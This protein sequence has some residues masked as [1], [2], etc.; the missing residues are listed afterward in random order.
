[1]IAVDLMILWILPSAGMGASLSKKP[2]KSPIDTLIEVLDLPGPVKMEGRRPPLPQYMLNLYNQ[3]ADSDGITRGKNPYGAEIIRSYRLSE[4][5][6]LSAGV[7]LTF[8]ISGLKPGEN[9]LEADLHLFRTKSKKAGRHSRHQHVGQVSLYEVKDPRRLEDLSSQRLL[10]SHLISEHAPGW[11]V[12]HIKSAILGGLKGAES[13]FQFL[14]VAK[15]HLDEPM[16]V[17]LALKHSRQPLI[18][19]YDQEAKHPRLHQNQQHRD[20][21]ENDDSWMSHTRRRRST[22]GASEKEDPSSLRTHENSAQRQKPQCSKLDMFVD[23][24]QIGLEQIISPKGYNAY[25]CDGACDYLISEELEPTNHAR[26]QSIAHHLG[27]NEVTPP[28]CVPSS[29]QS[30]TLL[31]FD[32]NH[33]VILRQYEDMVV[34]NCACH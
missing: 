20:L 34:G 10:G 7:V 29:L 15:D 6:N 8:N 4:E 31:F 16:F 12:F 26:V 22:T 1:M 24:H 17:T 25:W 5:Q 14:V 19:L 23:L 11:E 9:I 27:L 21:L 13:R 28:C 32:E 2:W 3:I 33:D 18:V 30:I